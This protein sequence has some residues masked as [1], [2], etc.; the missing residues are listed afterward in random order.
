[1][2]ESH[3]KCTAIQIF[4]HGHFS[5]NL[6]SILNLMSVESTLHKK[7]QKEILSEIHK[8]KSNYSTLL[9][10]SE[11][12]NVEIVKCNKHFIHCF[13]EYELLEESLMKECMRLLN[14]IKIPFK[15]KKKL[16]G[17]HVTVA[18]WSTT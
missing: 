9:T 8:C 2:C 4:K 15:K 14:S 6:L 16:T 11:E 5:K 10:M 1:M 12:I 13:F 17:V 3:S 18:S 7:F